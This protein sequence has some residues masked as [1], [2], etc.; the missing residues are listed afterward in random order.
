MAADYLLGAPIG[1]RPLAPMAP[2]LL[3]GVCL[4]QALLSVRLFG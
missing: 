2:A 4:T 3:S 1:L